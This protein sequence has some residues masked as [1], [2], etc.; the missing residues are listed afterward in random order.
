M[1]MEY[2]DY[3]EILGVSRNASSDDI[4][5]AYRKLARKYHPD[6]SKEEN[7]EEKFKEVKE[8]YE[9]LKDKE[10]RQAYDQLGKD[11]QAGQGFQA[12]PGWEYQTRET[13]FSE[14]MGPGEFSDFFEALFGR[15][16]QQ[17]HRGRGGFQQR[18]QDQH[19][20]INITLE[21][22]YHGCEKSIQLQQPKVDPNTGQVHLS[23]RHL[24]VKIP[25][26]V[27]NG[28]QIRLANQGAPGIGSGPNGDLYLE[29]AI[30]SHSLYTVQGKDIYLNLPIT[31]WE[32]ALGA[33][34]KVPT[35]AGNV[36][37]TVPP[38]SQTGKTLRLKGRGLGST[39][40][41][42]VILKIY[43]P[44][45]KNESQKQ[46]YRQMSEQMQ[47]NPREDLMRT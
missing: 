22:A 35:L 31:P 2:K 45:P 43:I 13:P 32:A 46:L 36:E 21:E 11:W 17:A 5:K 41:Q 24:K 9:V 30:L 23:T 29:I 1:T 8:A 18:G 47:F 27:S 6:V 4:K 39:G 42:Y 38:G 44:E 40:N 16:W 28:Q 15:G 26:G 12:P 20:K 33:K 3:Y 10:K 19:S 37:L 14:G 25:K 7:A 34:I